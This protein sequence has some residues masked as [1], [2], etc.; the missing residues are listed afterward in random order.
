MAIACSAQLSAPDL[1]FLPMNL[2]MEEVTPVPKPIVKPKA[3]KKS[4]MLNAIPAIASPPNRPMKII[5]TI[6]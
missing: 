1:S 2:A 3:R 5:S 4:G 6:L